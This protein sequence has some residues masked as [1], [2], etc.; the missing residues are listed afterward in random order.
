MKKAK[1]MVAAAAVVLFSS[2]AMA[3]DDP[4]NKVVK[5][6]GKGTWVVE[7]NEQNPNLSIIRIYNEQNEVIYEEQ[8]KGDYVRASRKMQ[9][10]LNKLQ[11]ALV[12]KQLISKSL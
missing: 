7:N 5:N 11:D 9:R 4:Q 10:K 6:A 3:A 8:L 2:V 1:M 12:N